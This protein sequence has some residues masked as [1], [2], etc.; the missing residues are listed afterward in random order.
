MRCDVKS[1][2]TFFI[3]LLFNLLIINNAFAQN[4]CPPGQEPTK[5]N[6]QGYTLECST[7]KERFQTTIQTAS[8]GDGVCQAKLN[9]TNGCYTTK[10]GCKIGPQYCS[11]Q[12]Y[13]KDNMPKDG[14]HWYDGKCNLSARSQTEITKPTCKCTGAVYDGEIGRAHV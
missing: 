8:T 3:F 2:F 14:E 10:G 12:I 9:G 4:S 7:V 1:T 5:R 13:C 11:S 6:R